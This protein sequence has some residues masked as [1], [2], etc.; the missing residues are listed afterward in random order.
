MKRN[1]PSETVMCD[2]RM[3]RLLMRDGEMREVTREKEIDRKQGLWMECQI[4][5]TP[6][7]QVRE[8]R[9]AP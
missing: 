3:L 6:N 2:V 4:K 8:S 5:E 7:G 1:E 9:Y